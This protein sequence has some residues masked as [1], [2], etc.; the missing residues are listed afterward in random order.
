M[1]NMLWNKFV[2]IEA[3]S[4]LK[5]LFWQMIYSN[6]LII[7]YCIILKINIKGLKLFTPMMFFFMNMIF[8]RSNFLFLTLSKSACL[9]LKIGFR[10]QN[11]FHH[12]LFDVVKYPRSKN[13]IRQKFFGPE[14]DK[15]FEWD[16]FEFYEHFSNFYMNS[17]FTICNY[18]NQTTNHYFLLIK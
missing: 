5:C 18:W 15:H 11:V 13:V 7:W 8:S 2:S 10:L 14:L 17:L 3:Y 16:F 12:V 6:L 9:I 4:A 1:E